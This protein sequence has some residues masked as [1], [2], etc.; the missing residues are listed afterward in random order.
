MGRQGVCGQPPPCTATALGHNGTWQS[1]AAQADA[2]SIRKSLSNLGQVK[3]DLQAG[4][5]EEDLQP[6]WISDFGRACGAKH[7]RSLCAMSIVRLWPCFWLCHFLNSMGISMGNTLGAWQRRDLTGNFLHSRLGLN[8]GIVLGFYLLREE[9]PWGATSA[10]FKSVEK[11]ELRRKWRLLIKPIKLQLQEGG[12]A[13]VFWELN[14]EFFL[15]QLRNYCLVSLRSLCA[16]ERTVRNN[17]SNYIADMTG[18]LQ[19][20]SYC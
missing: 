12:C 11:S 5:E 6:R 2:V 9:D 7:G 13:S 3:A 10:I 16:P 18:L 8:L 4:E 20:L 19:V 1:S 14:A 15:N 17:L